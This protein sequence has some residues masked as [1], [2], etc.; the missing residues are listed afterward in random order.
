MCHEEV[1]CHY[2]TNEDCFKQGQMFFQSSAPLTIIDFLIPSLIIKNLILNLKYPF[3][4]AFV[5]NVCKNQVFLSGMRS[6]S[7]CIVSYICGQ[8]GRCYVLLLVLT[9]LYQNF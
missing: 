6:L 7:V 9:C 1:R 4:A 3:V 2:G 8:N 5:K